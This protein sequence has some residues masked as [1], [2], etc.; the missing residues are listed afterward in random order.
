M[1]NSQARK[2]WSEQ[3]ERDLG[4]AGKRGK[5]KKVSS[6]LFF[7]ASVSSHCECTLSTNQ[8]GTASSLTI[9]LLILSPCQMS[10]VQ[11]ISLMLFNTGY[12][13]L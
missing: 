9:V 13:T 12:L 8:K 6:R 3:A 11:C 7:L 5:E 4:E 2:N 10:F 1:R